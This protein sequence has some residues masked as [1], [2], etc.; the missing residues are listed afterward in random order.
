MKMVFLLTVHSDCSLHFV[1]DYISQE[2]HHPGLWTE[3]WSTG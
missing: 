1:L 3:T 2:R